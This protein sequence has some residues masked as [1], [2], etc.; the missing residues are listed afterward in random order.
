MIDLYIIKFFSCW[1][2][3]GI[4]FFCPMKERFA[5][6]PLGIFLG[7]PLVWVVWLVYWVMSLMTKWVDDMEEPKPNLSTCPGC[8]GV[9]DNGHDRCVPP[10]PYYCSKCYPPITKVE[11]F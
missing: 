1:T 10:S 7:G 5:C 11:E 9:A 4:V 3:L 8:G 2:I 6:S